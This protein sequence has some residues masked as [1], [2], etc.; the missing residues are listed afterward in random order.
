MKLTL[1]GQV[2]LHGNILSDVR[3][4]R[5]AGYAALE[6]HTDKLA[7]YLEAGRTARELK[8]ALDSFG[9]EAAAIDII[10]GIEVTDRTGR[11]ELFERTR[12]L[13]DVA[14]T[15]GAPT[16][17]VKPFSSSTACTCATATVPRSVSRGLMSAS[18]AAFCRGTENS[19][20]PSGPTRSRQPALM[21]TSPESFS[22][23]SSGSA[24]TLKWQQTCAGG[25]KG[26][27]STSNG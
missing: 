23:G 7:R 10:G 9:I 27:F 17:Q 20:W 4:A 3:I 25:W 24:T 2:T 1:H 16:I 8:D 18:S 19:P 14:E 5:D 11:D 6:V 13:V 26:I 22:T 15:I 12:R 21:G